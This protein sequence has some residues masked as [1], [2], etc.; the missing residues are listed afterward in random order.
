[1]AWF[2]GGENVMRFRI[3][4]IACLLLL[5]ALPAA[6]AQGI[7]CSRARSPTEKAICASPAL[8]ALDSQIASAYADALARQ[9]DRRE[10]MHAG[11]LSWL[12]QRDAACTVPAAALERCLSGQMTARLAALAPPV[13]PPPASAARTE[14]AA[15]PALPAAAANPPS[16]VAFLDAAS[17]PASPE[18]DTLLHV[19]S[20]GRFTIAAH[21][22]TGAAL[23]LVDMLTGPTEAAGIAGAQD[24]RLDQLLDIGAYKLRLLSRPGATGAVAVTVTPFHDAAPPAALPPTGRTVST[25]LR[26]GEQRAF[27]L[28]VP[29]GDGANVRIEAAGRA[30]ADLRLWRDG[31]EM[32]ALQP[33]R[34]RIDSTPA[35]PLENLR[36]TGHVEPGTYLAIAYGGVA[37]PWTDGA[38]DQP[39]YLR[40]G[41]SPA[42]AE[43]FAGGTVGPFGSEVF[44]LPPYARLL[45]LDLPAPAAADIRVG[46]A[47]G[48]IQKNSREPHVVL[49]GPQGTQDV[50][51]LRGAAGQ[52][53]TLRA[54][55]RA[56]DEQF[57]RPG[58]WW[59]AAATTGAGG[60]ELPPTV[61]LEEQQAPDQ[62][63]RI[64]ASTAPRVGPNAPWRGRFNLRGPSSLL[65]Q[66]PAGG[67][68]AFNS[69]GV[70]VKHGRSGSATLPA[71]YYRLDLAPQT[72]S[73]GSL[74]FTLGT[75][76]SPPPPLAS[77]LP[78]DPVIPLGIYTLQRGQS[79]T[80]HAG[81]GPDVT[82]GLVARRVPVALAE[83]PL[84]ATVAAGDTLA[85]PVQIAPGGTLS[86]SELGVGPI[87]YGQQG[88]AG[89][90]VTVVIPVADHARTVA[91]G[92]RRTAV[93]LT[94]IPA[95]PAPDR[96][97]AVQAGTPAF[98]DLRRGEERGFTLAVPEGGLFRVETLGRLHTSGR[99]ATPFIPDLAS[100]DAGG[101]G[102]NMLIQSALRAGRYR[103]DVKAVDSAGHLGLLA[104]PA[105]LLPGSTLRPGGSVRASLPAGSGVAFPLDVMGGAEDSYHLDVLSLGAAWT[106]RLEDAEGWPVAKPGPLDG[107]ATKLR[108]GRYQIVVQPDA[109]A[110]RVAARLTRVVQP[111]EITG[112]GPHTLPFEAPQTATWRE[113]DRTGDPRAPDQ[114]NFSLP[115]PA[116]V[117]LTLSDGM[118]AE[119]HRA[120]E[121][122][123]V[124]RVVGKWTGDLEAG[125][126]QLDAT[127][128]GRNDR[129]T[130][131]I[132]LTSPDLQPGAAR[133]VTL[134]ATVAFSLAAP[135][136]ATLTSWGT[137]PV[138]AT[139]RRG[140][141]VVARY[142]ARPDDWNIA[143]SRLLPPGRYTMELQ[144]AAPPDLTPA[145][146][147]AANAD[148]DSNPP[149]DD[150]QE[151]QTSATKGVTA[152]DSASSTG[153]TSSDE[154]KE[155]PKV[156]L[157]LALP[158]VLPAIAAP[159][160][161]AL[162]RGDGVHVLSLAK[163]EPGSLVVAAVASSAPTVLALE[164]QE[165][166]GWRTVAI[167]T[168]VSPVAAAPSDGGDAAWRVEAW[169]VDGGP[170][171]IQM[172][173]RAITLPG[174]APGAVTLAALDGM[175]APV[176]AGRVAFAGPGIA[177]VDAARELLA[178][179][180]PGHALASAGGTAVVDGRDLWLLARQPVTATAEPLGI[181]SGAAVTMAL[182]AGLA[183]TLPG[184]ADGMVQLWRADSGSGQ[185]SLGLGAGVAGNSAVALASGPVT[186]RGDG[187][188]LR[189]TRLAPSLA[190]DRAVNGAAQLTIPAGTALPVT[191][192][193]G[194]KAVQL[195]LAPGIAAFAGWHDA[196]PAAVWGASAPV[197]RSLAGAWTELLLVNTSDAPAPARIA[198][199]PSPAAETLRPGAV[200]KRFYGAAGSFDLPFDA[201]AGAMLSIAGDA[202][203]TAVTDAAVA[204]GASIA[205]EGTGRAVVTHGPGAVAVWLTA[206]GVSPWPDAPAQAVSLPARLTLSGSAAALALTAERPMLLHV[207]TTAPVL[208]GLRQAGRD[209]A[210]ALFPAG[211][212]LH[213]AIAAGPVTLRLF[214]ADDGALGGTASVWAE[215]LLPL[216]EGLGAAVAVAP[217][218]AAAWSFTLAKA[219]TIGVGV[220]TDP[221]Q[222]QARL[223]NAA[224]AVVGEGVAQLRPLPA[225]DYVLEARVPATA[226]PT[227]LRPAL[228]GITPRG[229]GPP[230]DVAEGYLELVGMKPA[231]SAR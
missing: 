77:P 46:D 118:A 227:L 35:H 70:A 185:P 63:L 190:T 135:R 29:P 158:P 181:A 215:P 109:V 159:A 134:P 155:T 11:L 124:T 107:L 39:F 100:D 47:V 146:T 145:Q 9:P 62:P 79:L 137:V 123:P 103:V 231:G 209:D 82:T 76:G 97:A 66:V 26:D 184:A 122:S 157:R 194:D 104:S 148:D 151:Q 57:D 139:L 192:P 193:P 25:T 150:E 222:A 73:L 99:L 2:L 96:V 12:K 51:E 183:A 206:P 172:A 50:A 48:P 94:A 14:A 98:L 41:A 84:V 90:G 52:P 31:R 228:V 116:P 213:R 74:E 21:S 168:G 162:L 59:I 18:A 95:P 197:S 67:D 38:A 89:A 56:T 83:G 19:T 119:L 20:P 161:A 202:A 37:L 175:P 143:A 91:L 224:G 69:T 54:L 138:K 147:T 64:V 154:T 226:S 5:A 191:L 170:D 186:L 27:W 78:A 17:L 45:R 128:L 217:G 23:Q 126:W 112:H 22:A 218:G 223:L 173:A 174:S 210:P 225:G 92:W 10:A 204:R 53:Y 49:R 214:P 179:G 199:Q 44:A 177:S 178:G 93:A 111:V 42:L 80:L 88:G 171:A 121:A 113:P 129:L 208:A 13:S 58:T 127:S 55:D 30:L 86:V 108:P 125:D 115:G 72:G 32:A 110:R 102:L 130:Y 101:A 15:D 153:D 65:F 75:P 149:A 230:P 106:G 187:L 163:P 219:A 165:P 81:T 216:G 189:L 176:A 16:P 221:D 133:A 71:D 166:A 87:P 1:M 117:T 207:S 196:A 198:E 8:H 169:A 164:R 144:P 114:W 203:L 6:R 212:E 33:E 152:G 120:G 180:W 28:L 24:G 142:G 182:P 167:D 60:D 43:G 211:A 200:Q 201:P 4:A 220:R 132:G 7:D 141:A 68:V 131:T 140:D 61:L 34:L 229:N 156:E 188:R 40:S 3:A 160:Q 205:V 85:V 36:L 195:D 136:V 105:P